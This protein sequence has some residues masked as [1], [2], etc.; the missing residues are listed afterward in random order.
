MGNIWVFQ[1]QGRGSKSFHTPMAVPPPC[2]EAS[3]ALLPN[4][5]QP[6]KAPRFPAGATGKQKRG[7]KGVVLQVHAT[8]RRPENV[9]DSAPTP[10]RSSS[11]AVASWVTLAVCSQEPI[12]WA[13]YPLSHEASCLSPGGSCTVTVCWPGALSPDCPARPRL[14][15]AQAESTTSTHPTPTPSSPGSGR[16]PPSHSVGLAG[17]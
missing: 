1:G 12:S 7:E 5:H 14:A 2:S 17:S 16:Q 10:H 4:T 15:A 11:R 3:S 13:L 9:P 6:R 8:G